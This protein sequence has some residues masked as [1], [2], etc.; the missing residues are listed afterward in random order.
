MHRSSKEQQHSME[1][2]GRCNDDMLPA[3]HAVLEDLTPHILS[4]LDVPTLVRNKAVSRS[5][6]RLFTEAVDR[7]ARSTHDSPRAFQ[8]NQELRDAVNKYEKYEPDD[9]EEFAT[10]Y[11]W[12]IDKWDVS[13]VDDF[14]RIFQGKELFNEPIGSLNVSNGTKM[15]LMF[16]E[17]ETFHQGISAWD[18][19]SVREMSG[20]FYNAISFDQD[21][22]TWDMSNVTDMEM[23]FRNTRSDS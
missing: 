18:T 3:L 21:I 11:G 5:C 14:T 4:F 10:T 16:S 2:L 13:N 15:G 22:S 9:A 17:A 7:R 12:P 23:M 6:K 1:F 8:S 19:S 20:M